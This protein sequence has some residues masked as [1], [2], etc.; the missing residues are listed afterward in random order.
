MLRDKLVDTATRLGVDDQLRKMRAAVLPRYKYD[1][2]E[3]E[4]LRKLLKSCL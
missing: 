3:S 1:R 2:V 4:N